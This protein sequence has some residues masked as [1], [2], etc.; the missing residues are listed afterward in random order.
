[1]PEPAASGPD[2]PGGDPALK[3]VQLILPELIA[4][5]STV[6]AIVVLGLVAA[7]AE[8]AGVGMVL[9]LLAVMF[10]EP[11]AVAATAQDEGLLDGLVANLVGMFDG[12]V[13]LATA[14]L[15]SLIIL[16]IAI[17]TVHGLVVSRVS[18]ALDHRTRQRLF[19]ECLTMPLL[20]MQRRS[21]GDLYTVVEQHSS[22]V[23][24]VFEA[25][26]SALR[27]LLILLVLGAVLVMLAPVLAGSAIIALLLLGRVIRLADPLVHRAGHDIVASRRRM[28]EILIRALQAM[29]TLRVYGLAGA[30]IER[31]SQVSRDASAADHRAAVLANLTDPVSHV[32]ALLAVLV[33]A[34]VASYIDSGAAT[35]IVAVG[36]LY[37]L[38]PYVAA[39]DAHRFEMAEHLPSLNIVTRLLQQAPPERASQATV[40][41]AAAPIRFDRVSFRYPGSS[42]FAIEDVT[43]EIQPRGWT[44]IDGPS[45]AGKSTLVD[46]LLG[47]FE[48]HSGSITVGGVRMQDLCPERW[49]ASISVCGQDIELVRGT[50]RENILLANPDADQACLERALDIAQLGP[51]VASLPRGL[52]TLL[53]EQGNTLSGGQCQRVGIAR[54]MVRRPRLL[55]LDEATSALDRE[56][57]DLI[58]Q[59]IADEMS[60]RAVL[61]I[62]HQI[63]GLPDLVARF[64][65]GQLAPSQSSRCA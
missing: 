51:L 63:E 34:M 18:A 47:L 24:E 46:L 29:R 38:Q 64:S 11:S 28:S 32:S 5:K 54:A 65:I 2:A 61:V 8:T 35:L 9:L 30:Q 10:Y 57:Q 14:V 1:M 52:E 6:A 23:A 17:V 58:L 39:L 33:M 16:R 60:G 37:R 4:A 26:C 42:T 56:A 48:P 41:D 44:Q 3:A 13:G 49:R 25:V 43:L 19:T 31:F 50:L 27:E 15:V 7:L 20:D 40:S 45:G 21:W 12:H 53:G 59:G 36:L 22:S 55:V 62:G